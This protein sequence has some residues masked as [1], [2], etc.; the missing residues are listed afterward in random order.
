VAADRLSSELIAVAREADHPPTVRSTGKPR[1]NVKNRVTATRLEPEVADGYGKAFEMLDR[2]HAALNERK[3]SSAAA[4]GLLKN[5]A[6]AVDHTGK[7][8]LQ[9]YSENTD[10]RTLYKPFRELL[11]SE[12]PAATEA[13]PTE[14]SVTSARAPRALVA[15]AAIYPRLEV[16]GQCSGDS[17]T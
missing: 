2:I 17:A 6:K 4:R 11:R 13:T 10:K 14:Q 3:L 7:S 5:F 15:A 16:G 12:T 9:R 1:R 8:L